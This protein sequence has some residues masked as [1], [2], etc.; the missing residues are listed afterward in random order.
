MRVRLHTVSPID[1][2]MSDC[3]FEFSSAGL[4]FCQSQHP[5]LHCWTLLP[6]ASQFLSQL[7]SCKIQDVVSSADDSREGGDLV[8]I[9]IFEFSSAELSCVGQHH[10]LH[11]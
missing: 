10:D 1:V 11:C 8:C 3:Y 9:T 6:S 2:Q 7:Y 4:C 5:E